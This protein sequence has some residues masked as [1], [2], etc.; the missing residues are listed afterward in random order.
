M[1]DFRYK[2]LEL[3]TDAERVLLHKYPLFF[4]AVSYPDSYPS[5]LGGYG[6]ECGDGWNALLD[7]MTARIEPE[8]SAMIAAFRLPE[9]LPLLDRHLLGLDP[10]AA[11]NEGA[12]MKEE[13]EDDDR[14]LLPFCAQIKE[15]FGLLRVYVRRGRLGT[16]DA[17]ARISDAIKEAERKAAV[18]CERCGQ[19]GTLR[20]KG[21]LR[22]RC[23]NCEAS[24]GHG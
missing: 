19:P 9:Y 10:Y 22:V 1:T 12:G 3:A 17:Y 24:R 4:R 5:P 21:W 13:E 8:L 16:D 11:S 7:E 14:P 18:T 20:T 2:T 15:K 23:D 6:L